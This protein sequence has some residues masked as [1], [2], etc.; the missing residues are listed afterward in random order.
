MLDTLCIVSGSALFFAVTI[1]PLMYAWQRTAITPVAVTPVVEV[2][3]DPVVEV[4]EV[5]VIEIKPKREARAIAKAV[6]PAIAVV[7]VEVGEMPTTVHAMRKLLIARGI[8]GAAR[9]NKAQC[10]AAL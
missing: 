9:F 6:T 1:A 4:V 3:P 5:P 10:L 2:Q 8:K 7:T